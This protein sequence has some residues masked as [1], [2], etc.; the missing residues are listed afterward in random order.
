MRAYINIGQVLTV[1]VMGFLGY[2]YLKVLEK[3]NGMH[4]RTFESWLG[5]TVK[6][7]K[8]RYKL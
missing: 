6:N 3:Q 7:F 1:G 5:D 2:R 8:D 4:P